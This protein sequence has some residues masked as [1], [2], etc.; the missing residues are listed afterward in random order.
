MKHYSLL[1]YTYIEYLD[2]GTSH[3]VM[4]NKLRLLT[5]TIANESYSH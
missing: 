3:E 5:I 4:V 2:M 1:A